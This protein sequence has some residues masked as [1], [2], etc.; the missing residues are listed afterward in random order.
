MFKVRTRTAS[1]N[2]VETV[3]QLQFVVHVML[4]LKFN[5]LYCDIT[6]F[7]SMCAVPNMAVFCCP[8]I[9]CF[10]GELLRYFRN[11]FQMVP[12]APIVINITFFCIPHSLCFYC[13]GFTFQNPL[14]FF[15]DT[16]LYLLKFK[17]L[18]TNIFLIITV[19]IV[20][21]VCDLH[22]PGRYVLP[23]HD[24][25]FCVQ[26]RRSLFFN[27]LNPELNPICYLLAL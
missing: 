5:V 12:V 2:S 13:K 9:Q 26:Q 24:M 4:L 19:V 14:G 17:H 7:Q 25:L 27:P 22:L 23:L 11:N 16:V 3:L 21:V 20:V 15:L 8:L 18:S 10:S 1:Y 6:T